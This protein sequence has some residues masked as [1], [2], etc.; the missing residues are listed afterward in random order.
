MNLK[1]LFK[2]NLNEKED[3]Y[4]CVVDKRILLNR[5][6]E[7]I[8][9]KKT[10]NCFKKQINLFFECA[11]E[12]RS[13][14]NYKV[15]DYVYLRKGQLMRGEGGI[16]A[17][18]K[19]KL[20][21]ISNYGFISPDFIHKYNP[22]QKTPL[23][24]PVWNIKEDIYLRDYI[25][26]YSGVTIKYF[27]RNGNQDTKLI[28]Y[29]Q[30][31]DELNSVR[32]DTFVKFIMEQ[33]KEIRFLPSI[34]KDILDIAFIINVDNDLGKKLKKNDI[35][36]LSMD[37]NILKNFIQEYFMK[38]FI[39]GKRDDF[40]TNRESAILF[41]VPNNFIEGILVSR[42]YERD[43]NKI[44]ELKNLFPN[45]YICNLDGKVIDVNL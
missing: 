4:N 12:F 29:K 19:E 21:L 11:N 41:G 34:A 38:D 44:N 20:K 23:S 16:E 25:I 9:D 45:C 32:N 43:I 36:N 13:K 7:I 14:H 27:R 10:I 33:T 30:I 3:K 18:S 37:K 40:T 28:P 17:L 1:K 42:K 15:G 31:D 26:N 6:E 5:V 24:I 35:F 8:T 2:V 39:L 22:K